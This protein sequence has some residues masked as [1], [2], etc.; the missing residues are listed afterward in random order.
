M[1]IPGIGSAI[2]GASDKPFSITY[3]GN[4]EF[5]SGESQLNGS[6]DI[7]VADPG[8]EIF[9]VAGVTFASATTFVDGTVAGVA[10]T[11]FTNEFSSSDDLNTGCFVAL[12]SQSGSQTVDLNFSG[13]L[14]SGVAF[15]FKVLNRLGAGTNNTDSDGDAPAGATGNS[16]TLDQT[17]IS[18]NG[19]WLGVGIHNSTEAITWNN[20]TLTATRATDLSNVAWCAHRELQ[21]ASS[22]PSDVVSWATNALRSAASWAFT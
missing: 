3:L 21:S 20:G 19:F 18:A 15:V 13:T 12:P 17:T 9:V 8:K 22:T 7:G 6:I 1:I 14:G 11:K 5:T 2:T 10:V 4:V 16:V